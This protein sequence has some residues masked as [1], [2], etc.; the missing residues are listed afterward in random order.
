MHNSIMYMFYFNSKSH[1]Y[2]KETKQQL[3]L[4]VQ[5]ICAFVRLSFS[6]FFYMSPLFFSLVSTEYNVTVMLSFKGDEQQYVQ[7]LF[8]FLFHLKVVCTKV[9]IVPPTAI[10]FFSLVQSFLVVCCTVRALLKIMNTAFEKTVCNDDDDDKTFLLLLLLFLVR[11]F[12]CLTLSFS[13]FLRVCENYLK[14][15]ERIKTKDSLTQQKKIFFQQLNYVLTNSCLSVSREWIYCL[16]ESILSFFFV[17]F[18]V[19]TII[20]NEVDEKDK[21][22]WVHLSSERKRKKIVQR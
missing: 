15:Q 22:E 17:R 12:N 6:L 14:K 2:R 9:Q 8:L 21:A 18:Y 16:W 11:S 5:T 7:V 19:M 4:F 1:F 20:E 10:F 3:T 13:F